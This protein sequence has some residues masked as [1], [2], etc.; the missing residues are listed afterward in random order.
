MG[1]SVAEIEGRVLRILQKSPGTQGFYSPEKVR[2]AV[3]ESFDYVATKM[4]DSAIGSWQRKIR[5]FDTVSGQATVDIPNDVAQ[6]H[7]VRYQVGVSYVP[8][9]FDD[10]IEGVQ[11][12]QVSGVTQFPSRYRIMENK[13]YFNPPLGVGGPQYLMMEFSAYPE[14]LVSDGQDIPAEFDVAMQH[15]IKYRSASVLCSSIGK[16]MK[17]WQNYES[18]WF[19]AMMIIVNKRVN[20]TQYVREFEG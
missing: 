10:A 6:I 3:Q 12:T 4:F 9:M 11:Y 7:V 5:Y 15:Y 17:E 18:Q 8:I 13:I 1:I 20:S 2:D 19:E 16:A 14:R